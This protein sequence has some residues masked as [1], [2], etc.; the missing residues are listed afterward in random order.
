M[1]EK[2]LDGRDYICDEYTIVDMACW[3]WISRYEWQDIDL[4]QY[5][6]VQSWYKRLLD[7]EAVQKGYH[8]PKKVGE[9]PSGS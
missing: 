9:I 7:R 8:V 3:P 5:P 2:R 1:L 6:N 4:N